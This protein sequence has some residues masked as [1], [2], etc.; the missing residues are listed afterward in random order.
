[1]PKQFTKVTKTYS[2]KNKLQLLILNELQNIDCTLFKNKEDA[3]KCIKKLYH[4]ALLLYKGNAVVPLLKT[5]EATKNDTLFY[6]DDVIS[7]SMYNVQDDF[8]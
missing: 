4:D 6:V 2:T 7:I 3:S 1:M 5:H 8:S